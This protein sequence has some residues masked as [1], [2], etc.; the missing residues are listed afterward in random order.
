MQEKKFKILKEILGDYRRSSEEYLF[1]CPF[2]KHHKPK[3]SVNLDKG[4]K[5]WVCGWATPKLF[6][7]VRRLGTRQQKD[8]WQE[9]E[10][11]V[12]IGE[13]S[14]DLFEDKK[15]EVQKTTIPLPDEYISLANKTLP[16][17]ALFAMKYLKSRGITKE[18]IL[19]WKI[20]YCNSGEYANRVIVPSFNMQ[21]KVNFFVA[22]AYGN[23]WPKYKNPPAHRDIVFNEL[24]IDWEKPIVLV[25]GAFDAIKAGPNSIP[26]LGSSLRE[27]SVLF[28]SI[29]KNDAAVFL[30]MDKDANTKATYIARRLMQYDIELYK[31]DLK[32]YN[33]VGEMTKE[34][35]TTLRDNA[36]FLESEFELITQALNN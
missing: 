1:H 28:Q 7:V 23:D 20:G 2:C 34:G 15:E 32:E 9:L 13:F 21:G 22:R 4:A 6:R 5:C 14:L 27:E 17:S 25:E 35:F 10:G 19:Y 16:R 26:L 8:E 33:D 12:D 29:V 3:F 36:R 11:S 30:A 24:W 31:I 18:D